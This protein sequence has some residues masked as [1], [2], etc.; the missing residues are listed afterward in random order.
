MPFFAVFLWPIIILRGTSNVVFLFASFLVARAALAVTSDRDKLGG[1]KWLLYPPL[2]IVYA[3]LVILMIG[4]PIVPYGLNIYKY[5]LSETPFLVMGL[6]LVLLGMTFCIWPKLVR[7]IF[8]PFA[9]WWK[10]IHAVTLIIAGA[11]LLLA[12]LTGYYG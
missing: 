11:A 5:P 12:F 6:W 2:I 8:S 10:R 4:W 7:A 9:D 3:G 1:Q